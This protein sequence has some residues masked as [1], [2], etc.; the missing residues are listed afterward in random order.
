[1]SHSGRKLPRLQNYA[2][3]GS[4]LH[5]FGEATGLQKFTL[6]MLRKAAEGYIQSSSELQK[7]KHLN[8]HSSTVGKKVYDKMNGARRNVFLTNLGKQDF[9]Y[10]LRGASKVGAD[11]EKE[12]RAREESQKKKL[13]AKAVKYLDDQKKIQPWDL[14]P[15][16]VNDK[17]ILLL[18]SVF[19]NGSQ[20]IYSII[21]LI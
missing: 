11:L 10:S 2:G 18:K 9:S 4:L 7:D 17:E 6:K 19:G 21:S 14:R 1:M 15:S 3:K 12:R 8:Y 16:S 13:T 20:G 5:L